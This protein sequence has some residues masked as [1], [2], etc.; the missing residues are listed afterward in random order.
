MVLLVD[1]QVLVEVVDALGEQSNLNL[2]RTG[3]TLVTGL[4]LDDFALFHLGLPPCD[5]LRQRRTIGNRRIHSRPLA[6]GPLRIRF[7]S[8]L[9]HT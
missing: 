6:L 4:S 2:G 8:A 9:S 3:V 1:L 7:R 5:W